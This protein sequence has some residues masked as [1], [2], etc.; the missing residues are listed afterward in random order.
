ML[1]VKIVLAGSADT[2][3]TSFIQRYFGDY[4]GTEKVVGEKYR[5]K[6]VTIKGE[7]YKVEL[8]ETEGVEGGVTVSDVKKA[9]NVLVLFS[10]DNRDSL[11]VAKGLLGLVERL[12]ENECRI[13]LVANKRDLQ[14]KV[15]RQEVQE[16]CVAR[17]CEFKEVSCLNEE[18]VPTFVNELVKSC[19]DDMKKQIETEKAKGKRE[20]KK[21]C[22]VC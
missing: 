16:I 12:K 3:K 19:V 17:S 20:S 21:S 8:D 10:V 7:T 4:T 15:T 13:L 1:K 6:D 14:W 5:E 22:A 11:S 2:G 18:E 9:S